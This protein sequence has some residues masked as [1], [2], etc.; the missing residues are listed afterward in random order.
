MTG[1]SPVVVEPGGVGGSAGG[2]PG[3]R[4]RPCTVPYRAVAV[5]RG[6]LPGPARSPGR[7][8]ASAAPCLRGR[9]GCRGWRGGAGSASPGRSAAGPAARRAGP[10]AGRPAGSR[11]TRRR[12]RPGCPGRPRASARRRSAGRRPRGA[13]RRSPRSR[14]HPGP[15]GP[16]PAPRSTTC[17]PAPAPRSTE[18]G[19]PGIICAWPFAAPVDVAEQPLRAG[20]RARPQPVAHIDR[21]HDPPVRPPAAAAGPASDRRSRPI[22]TRPWFT[23]SY[24]AP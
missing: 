10:P 2:A 23:A 8:S 22:S 20:G 5:L 9:P 1:S 11:R 19:Q 24:I 6:Q 21:Q 17:A 14:R 15:A 7:R 3:P 12:R 18:Y 16:R 4:P 13:G